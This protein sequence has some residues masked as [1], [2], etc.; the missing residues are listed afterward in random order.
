MKNG[1]SSENDVKRINAKIGRPVLCKRSEL[2]D[3]VLHYSFPKFTKSLY[4]LDLLNLSKTEKYKAPDTNLKNLEA[5][6][7]KGE[8][9]SSPLYGSNVPMCLMNG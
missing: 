2:T 7:W 4:I 6:F 8:L 5:K 1:L 9:T 3:G